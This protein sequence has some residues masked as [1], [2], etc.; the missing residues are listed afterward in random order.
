M[1]WFDRLY[2]WV[3]DQNNGIPI[4]STRMD[5]ED[6]NFAAGINSCLNINGQ[7]SPTSN[8][9]WGGFLI[10]N[11]GSGVSSTDAA[12]VSQVQTRTVSYATDS[13][14]TNTYVITLSPALTV[15]V[16]GEKAKF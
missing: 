6:N 8:I 16:A 3:T 5:A 10:N 11:L 15:N 2:S 14:S 7:N 13:G 9:S 4:E 12:N 1:S